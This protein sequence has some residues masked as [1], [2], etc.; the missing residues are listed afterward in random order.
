MKK[1][2]GLDLGVGSVGWSLINIDENN[3]PCE[4]VALGSRIVP[5]TADDTNQFT[6]GQAIT[7]NQD[8]TQKRTARK[9]YDRYQQRRENLT[10]EF[11]SHGML[12]DERLIKLPVMELWQLRA[13]AATPGRK[14]TLPEIGR[15][16]YHINQRRGYKHAKADENGD[17]TQRE[18]VANVNK[19]YAMIIE[20]NQTIGLYFAEQLKASKVETDKGIFYTYRIKEQVFPRKAYEAEFDQIMAVQRE[21]YADVF[22]DAFI[23]RLR[24]EI[25]FYQRGLKS[26]KHLVSLCEFEKKEYTNAN[27]ETVFDGPKVAPRTSPLFQLCKIW[28]TVNNIK[29][30]NRR[31]EEFPITHTQ[32]V[33]MANFLDNHEKMLLKDLFAILGVTAKDGWHGGK[34]FKNGLQGNTTKMQLKKAL[35]GIPGAEKLLQFDIIIEETADKNTGE[36]LEIVS[37]KVTKQPLYELWHTIYSISDK[38]ELALVLGKKHKITD[39]SVVSELF[40]LDFVKPGYGNKST[41]AMRRI[42]PYL[43]QGQMYSEACECAG[44]RHSESLTKEENASRALLKHLPQ[45]KK[46]ELRQPIVEKILNQMVNVVNAL[47]DKHGKIDE[48]RV[49]LARELKQSKDERESL[50]KKMREQ[51]RKNEE[52][53]SKIEEFDVSVS[54]KRIQKYR[55]WQESEGFCFY[56]GEGVS[57]A[58][59]LEGVDAEIEHIIP[60]ALLFDDSFS[61]KVCACR[62]CNH[63]KGKMTAY[64]FVQTLGDEKF[65]LYLTR[66]DEAYKNHT[67]SKTKR[68]RLLTPAAKIPE[69]FIE[70]DLR[71][72]QYI[73]RKSVEMLKQVCRDVHS[74]TGSVTDFV[75]RVWGYDNVLHNLN[76]ERYRKGDLTEMVKY[77]HRGQVHEE[78]RIKDWTKRIDHRH[79]A[80]DALVIAMTSQAIIQ[81]LN[82]L[83]TERDQMFKEVEKQSE[84]WR[85]DYS[86][87]EQWLREKPH[88]TVA[89]VE[90]AVSKIAV[91]FKAGK[92]VA[93]LNKRVKYVQGKKKVLQRDVITPRGALSQES[94]YGKIRTLEEKKPIKYAF[95]NP[96]LI[97]KGY[98]KRLVEERLDKYDGNAKQAIAS[99]KKDPIMIGKNRDVELTYATCYKD[100]YV[101][102]YQLSSFVKMAD[103]DSIVDANIRQRVKMRVAQ[104]GGKVKDALKDLENNPVYAD[105]KCT[106]PIKSVRCFTGLKPLAVTPVKYD[107]NGM[108]MGY[109]KPGN[110]HHIAIYRDREGNLQEHITTFW[111]A[112]ER[113]KY[114]VPVVIKSPAEV[115]D[116]LTDRD[117]LPEAFLSTLPDVTWTFVE[118]LQQNE[119]FIIGMSDDEYND[120]RRNNDVAALCS[121]LYR[122]QKLASKYYIFR[123]HIETS[124]DDKYNGVKNEVLSK[125]IG[126]MVGVYSLDSYIK[127]NLHKVKIDILG[128]II[129]A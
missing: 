70:R 38:A 94:V 79:H 108:A 52:Y 7:K 61:N 69:D 19:R 26:C 8:R 49:E 15:V 44:F 23:N 57:C 33:E 60:R 6:K 34:Q 96:D 46:N 83:N 110:N 92:K 85:N 56:C 86:L 3:V 65:N 48:I 50:D 118:S 67:I 82:K 4:I 98:I 119:M 80:V 104:F 51:E 14:L 77:D 113:M 75:R 115:W 128:N 109:V 45:I 129:D 55:L 42:L 97:F 59:F 31:N 2:L 36:V 18:Y 13:D 121:H 22:T 95:E 122:V 114:G 62:K 74:S 64:D 89:E 99:L 24:N 76:L 102:K 103:I 32:R 17:K 84:E 88:F 123:L 81:R 100:E 21:F 126:K 25:I 105:D 101:I 90:E 107:S 73:S 16:L 5:L 27:G 112:V 117:D 39:E 53:K 35:G 29:V 125:E 58:S 87:L 37:R 91:S 10:M 111:T 9:G 1:V 43:Q 20:R 28:E 12:P 63:N 93:T 40:K 47:I 120:A 30:T 116:S 127:N 68:D 124:V 41:K 11:R 66:V 54:R 78:E 71:L 106:I 72:T